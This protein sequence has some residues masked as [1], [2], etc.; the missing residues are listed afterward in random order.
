MVRIAPL[1]MGYDEANRAADQIAAGKL[2]LD[3]GPTVDIPRDAYFDRKP[4]MPVVVVHLINSDYFFNPRLPSNLLV[5]EQ[6][7]R[8]YTYYA[9]QIAHTRFRVSVGVVSGG[10]VMVRRISPPLFKIAGYDPASSGVVLMYET[11]VRTT[12]FSEQLL[13][14]DEA[15]TRTV[16]LSPATFYFRSNMSPQSP[17]IVRPVLRP[18]GPGQPAKRVYNLPIVASNRERRIN[19]G[20]LACMEMMRD[21]KM[22]FLNGR[23]A[24]MP[25]NPKFAFE[26]FKGQYPC[27]LIMMM[28]TDFTTMMVDN[29]Q[30][31]FG[32]FVVVPGASINLAVMN[33]DTWTEWAQHRDSTYDRTIIYHRMADGVDG[34]SFLQLA[35]PPDPEGRAIVEM[36]LTVRVQDRAVVLPLANVEFVGSAMQRP[37]FPVLPP[38]EPDYLAQQAQLFFPVVLDLE[39]V[40][41]HGIYRFGR[42][43]AFANNLFIFENVEIPVWGARRWQGQDILG[44]MLPSFEDPEI[45]DIPGY[46]IWMREKWETVRPDLGPLLAEVAVAYVSPSQQYVLV[47]HSGQRTRVSPML[48]YALRD[49]AFDFVNLGDAV[50]H[51]DWAGHIQSASGDTIQ[52]EQPVGEIVARSL[53]VPTEVRIS[54]NTGPPTGSP[55]ALSDVGTWYARVRDAYLE[56]DIDNLSLLPDIAMGVETDQHRWTLISVNGD[57][58]PVTGMLFQMV[59][60][61]AHLAV[62]PFVSM[63]GMFFQDEWLAP[64]TIEGPNSIRFREP[65]GLVKTRPLRAPAENKRLRG[66]APMQ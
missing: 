38:V 10:N 13:S 29:D 7:G 59:F 30:G 26:P 19:Q 54:S 33:D 48:F 24:L 39:R 3:T 20:R 2:T 8:V 50:V 41:K 16:N 28:H 5:I 14:A 66:E 34:V 64:A 37:G 23:V 31:L 51:P 27:I 61:F 56:S 21:G 4:T 1:Q 32:V 17:W 11:V 9:T 47:G 12:L 40:P 62:R 46:L 63:A 60:V 22:R 49:V 18:I 36:R 58:L 52:L 65:I 45:P 6:H 53:T 35:T 43:G 15:D 42:G 57:R 44:E 25:K 55:G